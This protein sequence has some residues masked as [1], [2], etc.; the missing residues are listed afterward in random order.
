EFDDVRDAMYFLR[1]NYYLERGNY[2]L[3]LKD[4]DTAIS[5]N[6]SKGIYYFNKIK[7]Y[8]LVSKSANKTDKRKY[9]KLIKKNMKLIKEK[10][11]DFNK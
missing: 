8:R 10:D 3:A 6:P 9:E 11:P 2:E 7:I 4:Y 1:G 5:L